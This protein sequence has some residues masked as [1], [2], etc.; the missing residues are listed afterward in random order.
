MIAHKNTKKHKKSK[1]TCTQTHTRTCTHAHAKVHKHKDNKTTR[2]TQF[3][4]HR[5]SPGKARPPIS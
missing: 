3:V 5:R 4:G 1:H 2:E